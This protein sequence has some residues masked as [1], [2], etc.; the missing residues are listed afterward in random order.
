TTTNKANSGSVTDVG[1]N[2]GIGVYTLS[3]SGVLDTTRLRLNTNVNNRA[4][5][6]GGSSTIGQLN[7]GSGIVTINGGTH[8]VT[9]VTTTDAGTL[10]IHGGTLNLGTRLDLN[11]ASTIK[12][13]VPYTVNTNMNL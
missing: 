7:C 8:T 1:R 12:N 9:G 11:S 10:Y 5:L 4:N 2:N 3:G 13:D 6:N